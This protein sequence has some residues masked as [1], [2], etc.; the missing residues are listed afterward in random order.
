[1]KNSSASQLPKWVFLFLNESQN[2][3]FSLSVDKCASL[4]DSVSLSQMCVRVSWL[5]SGDH[6]GQGRN[7]YFIL[8]FWVFL[9]VDM[10]QH[11]L[12]GQSPRHRAAPCSPKETSQEG[13]LGGSVGWATNFGSG[14][15]LAVFEFEPRV[16]LC[17]DR[18]EQIGRAH[19]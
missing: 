15:D 2:L 5:I 4:S 10:F 3:Q 11:G 13:C 8:Q 16:G 6:I 9:D 18:S 19:V 12:C 1:M 7:T 17:A 14:H